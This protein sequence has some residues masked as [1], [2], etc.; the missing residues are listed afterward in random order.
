[1]YI[2]IFFYKKIFKFNF[3]TKT[4]SDP[5]SNTE[6][7]QKKKYNRKLSVIITRFDS[8]ILC[9]HRS[10]LLAA[11]WPQ[12][13]KYRPQPPRA[14]NRV[15]GAILCPN[16]ISWTRKKRRQGSGFES[17]KESIPSSLTRGNSN[18]CRC[19]KTRGNFRR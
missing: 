2:K 19:Y 11:S 3:D 15:S 18:R 13:K 12:R 7:T 8:H 17:R 10:L 9:K 16:G 4:K 5:F 14:K 1:M 6:T